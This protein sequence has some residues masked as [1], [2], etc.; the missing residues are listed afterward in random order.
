MLNSSKK[1]LSNASVTVIVLLVFTAVLAA[2]G[3]SNTVTS[4]PTTAAA[5]ATAVE[6]TTAAA[7]TTAA[8]T[9]ATGGRSDYDPVIAKVVKGIGTFTEVPLDPAFWGSTVVNTPEAVSKMYVSTRSY[10]SDLGSKLDT[11]ATEAGYS[12]YNLAGA[13]PEAPGLVAYGFYIR[14]DSADL[15]V[16][17]EN[18]PTSATNLSKE[19]N[20]PVGPQLVQKLYDEIKGKKTML[21]ITATPG[22][23]KKA[24]D[25]ISATAVTPAVTTR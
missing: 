20:V 1:Q 11:A 17:A 5:T 19:L 23:L 15:L 22:V 7:K 16:L 21:Y 4:V 3:D 12:K 18:V 6:T 13:V 9:A 24:F 14:G 10:T 2:C 8:G 25:K